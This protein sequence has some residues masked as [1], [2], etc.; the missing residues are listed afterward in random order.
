MSLSNHERIFSHDLRRCGK[1]CFPRFGCGFAEAEVEFR[2]AIVS[3]SKLL[4]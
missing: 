4:N 1:S 3:R 2:L